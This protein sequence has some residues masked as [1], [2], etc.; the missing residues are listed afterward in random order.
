MDALAICTGVAVSMI[1]EDTRA[2]NDNTSKLLIFHVLRSPQ[3]RELL[4]W[5]ETKGGPKAVLEDPKLMEELFRM[6]EEFTDKSDSKALSRKEQVNL[7]QEIRR[8]FSKAVEDLM[9]EN[10]E[11]F[12]MKLNTNQEE[13]VGTIMQQ[14]KLLEETM[15]KGPHRRIRDPV[16]TTKILILC[17]LTT[18]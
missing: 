3:D 4:E 8:E 11:N 14:G 13:L 6:G 2:I 15:R 18:T 12:L 10:Q 1:A 5:I 9:K 7:T 17:V 16:R